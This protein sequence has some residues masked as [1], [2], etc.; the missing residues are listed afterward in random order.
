MDNKQTSSAPAPGFLEELAACW[1]QLPNKGLFFVL[2]A[3]WMLLFHFYGNA[4]FGYIRDSASLPVWMY[5]TYNNP[6]GHGED[7]HGNLIPF[8]VLAL[9]WWKRKELLALPNHSWW[10]GFLLLAFAL[11]LHVFGYMI[12]Q[13]RVS[14]V[15]LF[16]GIYALMGLAW[17]PGWLRT[18]FFPFFLFV[19]C[20]PITSIGEPITVPLR[21]AVTRIVAGICYNVLGMDVLRQGNNLFNAKHTYNYEVAAACSGIQSLVAISALS[22]I[23]AFMSL[24]KGWKRILMMAAAVPLAMLSNVVRML[25]IICAAELYGQSGGN[26]VHDSAIFSV[27]PYIP[28]IIGVAWLGRL[29]REPL[30]PPPLDFAAKPV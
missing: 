14:I 4:T 7:G 15:A 16:T 5:K 10:P 25:F 30:S 9:F 23:Y 29:L 6:M 27:L 21:L 8:V 3:A 1:Q 13:P 11:A 28:A 24:E 18:S 26:Y 17:G 20:I 19:F 22:T 12:Q 2:L